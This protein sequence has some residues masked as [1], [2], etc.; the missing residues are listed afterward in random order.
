MTTFLSEDEL[1]EIGL[2]VLQEFGYDWLYG[3]EIIT[4]GDIS[5]I[6][7]VWTLISNKAWKTIGEFDPNYKKY[8]YEDVDY[9]IRA[10][11]A[12]FELQERELPLYHY[13]RGSEPLNPDLNLYRKRNVAYLRNKFG[14]KDNDERVPE[15]T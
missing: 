15:P 11:R 4:R 12:G 5:Y 7:G 2:D 1:E 13:L 10:E 8:S 3:P 14:I 9:S 6:V